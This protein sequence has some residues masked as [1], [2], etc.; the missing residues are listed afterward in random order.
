M[1]KISKNNIY[2]I[3]YLF[4]Q[5]LTVD[6]ISAELNLTTDNIQSIIESEKLIVQP[7]TAKDLMINKTSVKKNNSVSIMTKEA[8]MMNDHN[9]AKYTEQT[10][11]AKNSHI[12]NPF[13][14]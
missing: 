7:P 13:D 6:Q 11:Q 3:K 4:A 10:Q 8:S 12:F 2:A 14:K 1:A 9:R 5:G